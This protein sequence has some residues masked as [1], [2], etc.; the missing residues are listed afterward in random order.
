MNWVSRAREPQRAP[1][2]EAL[3][4]NTDER[5]LLSGVLDLLGGARDM[6]VLCSFLLA[7]RE[8]GLAVGEAANRGVRTYVLTSAEAAFSDGRWFLTE[9]D[10]AQQ[11][12]HREALRQLSQVA[13]VRSAPNWHTK[14]ILVDPH[15][16]PR[17]LLLSANLNSQAL[18]GSPE[19]GVHLAETEVL[20][21]FEI[22][23]S[24]FWSAK[25]EIRGGV[26][27]NSPSRRDVAPPGNQSD[28]VSTIG[29][30]S[31]VLARIQDQLHDAEN[32]VLTTYS[33]DGA[34]P[35]LS[36]LKRLAKRGSAITIMCHP[37]TNNATSLQQLA[38]SGCT[39]LGVDW[40]HAKLIDAG[41]TDVLMVSQNLDVASNKP[42]FETAMILRDQ[43]AHDAQAWL[44]YW[45]KSANWVMQ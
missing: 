32:V 30:P 21:L 44:D 42:R 12:K 37:S 6:V 10:L 27:T 25:S 43:R 19:V 35:V 14:F 33:V 23:R 20:T 15:T 29:N 2:T 9:S 22:A 5:N 40:L 7:S 8:V 18:R 26:W 38:R 45:V 13:R 16:N 28:I 31:A 17:G 41:G 24:A 36:T 11:S 1:T 4:G 3:F 34:S 39:V